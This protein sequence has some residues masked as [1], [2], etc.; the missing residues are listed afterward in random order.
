MS[1][2]W[3]LATGDGEVGDDGGVGELCFYNFFSWLKDS[4]V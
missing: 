2:H 3:E 1:D 4:K